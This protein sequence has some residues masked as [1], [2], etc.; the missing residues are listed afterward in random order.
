MPDT[1][2]VFEDYSTRNLPAVLALADAIAFQQRL[3]EQ[4]KETRLLE[5][6]GWFRERVDATPSLAWRSARA[7]ELSCSL[8]AVGLRNA[9]AAEVERK[10]AAADVTVRPFPAANLN[11]L[12]VSPNLINTAADAD[13]FIAAVTQ[14]S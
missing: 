12:R 9:K 3:G 11:T 6:A 14:R 13:R 2:E 4:A 7:P 1:A 5:I 10:L 8:F